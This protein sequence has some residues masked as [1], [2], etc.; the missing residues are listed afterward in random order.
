[1]RWVVPR[2]VEPPTFAVTTRCAARRPR[3]L[4]AYL[5]GELDAHLVDGEA[6]RLA[7][8]RRPR[9]LQLG[10]DLLDDLGQADEGRRFHGGC[11][12]R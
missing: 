4:A 8:G 9:L 7:L 2:S 5:D 12:H 1:M 11:P 10:A 6:D 3:A